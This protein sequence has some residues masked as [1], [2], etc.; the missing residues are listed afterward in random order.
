MKYFHY[1]SLIALFSIALINSCSTEEEDT[2]PPQSVVA[3]PEPEPPAPTQYT[4]TVTA[5]EGGTVSTEGGT[6]D[7]GTEVTITATPNDGYEFVGWEGSNSDSNSLTVTLNG[8]T[9][10][11]ALFAQLPVLILPPSPS[12]MFT[13]GVADTISIRFRSS[14][15]FKSV[16]LE[17]NYGTVEVLEQ[18]EEGANEGNI[19]VQYTPL[20]V[21]NIDFNTTI[22]G[23][24]IMLLQISLG[25]ETIET[26]EYKI[27]T[28][29]EPRQYVY[30]VPSAISR[31]IKIPL[32]VPL[33]RWLN[34]KDNYRQ[35]NDCKTGE[36]NLYGTNGES[37]NQFENSYGFDLM[38]N[39][40][41]ADLNNDGY[42]DIIT[43]P[44]Y[45]GSDGHGTK[46]SEIEVYMYF[47]GE[48]K[49]LDYSFQGISFYSP[50][51][52]Q[53]A[54]F[55]LDGYPDI[56]I[57]SKNH[58][59]EEIQTNTLL[60]IHNGDSNNIAFES[61]DLGYD[62][63]FNAKAIFDLNGDGT[64]DFFQFIDSELDRSFFNNNSLGFTRFENRF[65]QVDGEMNEFLLR[66][67]NDVNIAD[68]NN[69]G[70]PDLI[71]TGKQHYGKSG[72]FWGD[73]EAPHLWV[74][75]R[76]TEIPEVKDWGLILEQ[77]IFD[78]DG[79]GF[80]EIILNRTSA[81]TAEGGEDDFHLGWYF[82]V[83][84]T[85]QYFELF[86]VTEIYFEDYKSQ[87]VNGVCQGE[88]HYIFNMGLFDYDNDGNI[89]YF[90]SCDQGI[91]KHEWEW[92]GSK[93][94]KVSP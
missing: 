49:F 1:L 12:K 26:S 8:D 64:L 59:N 92:N 83:V 29:P 20:S 77:N 35:K 15:G 93:F 24:E 39:V 42:L 75:G 61:L 44:G 79:D 89:E 78:I 6:Y 7:E 41:F 4:L 53:I 50:S 52:F 86:D 30:N 5:G 84:E 40:K 80:L 54:D 60:L 17:A 73:D 27:R 13:K 82:Q 14:A 21:E 81:K 87:R 45:I 11:Q 47:N 51:P 48:Y 9:T 22:A 70:S 76:Y 38:E 69:D 16:G 32:D 90:N 33:I 46:L 36:E 65:L 37:L 10:V 34:K 43:I 31:N 72:V 74:Q 23:F 85:N 62:S 55:N 67:M 71:V 63:Q 94:I 66:A 57:S 68:L 28:Q 25:D 58:D 56:L 91:L 18:P 2:S 19:V 3:T 88:N